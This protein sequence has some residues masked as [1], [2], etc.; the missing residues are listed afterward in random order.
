[1][2]KTPDEFVK[3]YTGRAIDA[4]G[5]Y[6]VQCVDGFRVFCNWA[7][8]RSWPTGNGWADGYWYGRDA[9]TDVFTAVDKYH[10]KDGDWVMWARGSGSHPSSHIAMY[11][12]GKEFGQNQGGNRG[13]CLKA[14]NFGDCL[15]GLRWKGWQTVTKPSSKPAASRHIVKSVANA[16]YRVYNTRTGEH[17][18]TASLTEAQSLVDGGWTDEG[19]CWYISGSGTPVYRFYNGKEHFWTTDPK[20][21]R[22]G[23]HSE[24]QAWK[25]SGSTPVYRFIKGSGHFY[26]TDPNGEKFGGRREG[27]AFYTGKPA[28]K[29]AS[30]PSKP[31]TSKS[32]VKAV[33]ATGIAKSFSNKIAKTYT[34][35]ADLNVR[36][37]GST[38]EKILG[39]LP[40]GTKFQCY[41]YYTGDF[42]Y[43]VATA[44]GVTY[45]GFVHRAYLK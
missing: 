40:K 34:T 2:A 24:G 30:K 6:G 37:G 11:Y 10:L 43:G 25:T 36:N 3:Q 12:N 7:F 44:N 1:M 26:T 32:T 9:H 23:G 15:G 20:G 39:T 35:T 16:V 19:V 8:G 14:T 27:V 45:T 17:L 18:Y 21:E 28:A 4:D 31:A 29:P 33:K 42:F 22:F 41:G 13:F 5:A 38:K